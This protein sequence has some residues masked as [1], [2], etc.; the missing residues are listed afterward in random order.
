MNKITLAFLAFT[1]A[2]VLAAASHAESGREGW[3]GG[4]DPG[5]SLPHD[6][7]M[8]GMSDDVLTNYDQHLGPVTVNG[9]TLPLRD[10]RCARGSEGL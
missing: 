6:M 8:R 5:L 7:D 10:P 9:E 2:M 1:A 3:Y 4:P